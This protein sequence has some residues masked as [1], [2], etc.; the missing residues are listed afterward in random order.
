MIAVSISQDLDAV[1]RTQSR[2]VLATL[3]RLLGSFEAAE[4]ALHEAFVAAAEQW[5]RDGFPTNPYAWLVSAGRFRTIDRWRRQTKLTRAFP[6][7]AAQAETEQEYAMAYDIQDDELRLIFTCC[8]PAL[9]P[10]ARIALT[11]REVGGLTTEEI[12]RAYLTRPTTV[13]QRIVRAKVKIRDEALPYEV[14]DRAQWPS[15]IDSVL[16]VIYL[17]FNEGYAASDGPSLARADLSGEAIRLGSLLMELV[18]ESEVRG[19]L[20]LMQIHEARRETR[21]DS[22]GDLVLLEDQD[23]SRWNMA[24]ISAA[25]ELLNRSTGKDAP[26]PYALEAAI[27]AAHA[28]APSFE[29]TDWSRI[30]TLYDELIRVSPSSVVALNRAVAVGMRDGAATGLAAIEALMENDRLKSYYLAHAARADLLR[31]LGSN[32]A[33]AASYRRALELTNQPAEQ[34]FL[35]SRLFELG[36]GSSTQ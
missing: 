17:I 7:L 20:A 3:I 13:A 8:H 1:Y 26:G 32:D 10:D 11:L 12:A 18:N 16:R 23:R 25:V 33:A 21:S 30:V 14:P 31:R 34:R 15:R 2:R 24:A 29:T 5:P 6:E 9:A 36:S 28:Q 27:A 4:E 19:L 22:A 35:S